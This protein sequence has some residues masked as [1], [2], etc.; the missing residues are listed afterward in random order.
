MAGEN[1]VRPKGFKKKVENFWYYYKYY[2]IIGIFLFT[3]LVVVVAQCSRRP[4]Y[5]YKVVVTT[6]SADFTSIQIETLGKKLAAYGRDINGDGSVNVSVVDCTYNIKETTYE[7]MMA[8]KQKLQSILTSEA[9]V[10]LIIS[11]EGNYDWINS[12]TSGGFM[13][14]VGLPQGDGK[15]FTLEGTKFLNSVKEECGKNCSWP[16][17]LRISRR[18]VKGT[19]IEKDKNIK[20]LAQNSDEL[21]NKLVAENR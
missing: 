3:A 7:M 4:K 2:C 6:N 14:N 1:A 21:L 10:L 13:E 20:E 9:G 8:K 18:I 12:I 17:D 5:D 11:D 19:L 15:Y 16:N